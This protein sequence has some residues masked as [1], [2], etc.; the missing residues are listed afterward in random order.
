M[1]WKK[2]F[3]PQYKPIRQKMYDDNI[4]NLHSNWLIIARSNHYKWL[5]CL[6]AN[7]DWLFISHQLFLM[8]P[9]GIMYIIHLYIRWFGLDM[10]FHEHSFITIYCEVLF[11][12]FWGVSIT[13]YP[14]HCPFW[15]GYETYGVF[16]NY[17]LFQLIFPFSFKQ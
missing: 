2:C 5:C 1:W 13:K 12:L 9:L 14:W 10:Y 8:Y 17:S 16:D 3:I 11:L 4:I 6:A 15:F 7:K